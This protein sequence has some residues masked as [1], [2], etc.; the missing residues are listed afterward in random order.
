MPHVVAIVN[1]C[2]ADHN[3]D[4][5]LR[6]SVLQLLD[7]LIDDQTLGPVFGGSAACTTLKQML[8]PPLVWRAGKTASALRFAGITAMASFFTHRLID[9]ETLR[10][11]LDAGDLL[12]VVFQAL[13]EDYYPDVRNTACYVVEQ[14]ILIA[15]NLLGDAHRRSL[16][17][18]LCK[19]LD[20]SND[21]V[22]I[23]ACGPLEAFV[24]TMPVDYCPTNSGYFVSSLLIHM[25]DSDQRIQE[26]VYK[27]VEGVA[28]KKPD[29][30]ETEIEKV[31]CRFRCKQYC[32][33]ALLVC[34]RARED[35]L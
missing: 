23:S 28:R 17:P 31:K 14:L 20:D 16:Y 10:D 1:G 3:R 5:A 18:E 4:P 13:E 26:A 24:A 15:G 8:L 30:V 32:D 35:R 27:I 12:P 34:R 22:R 6:L 29:V 19:R 33:Q 11:L 9:G 2:L 7:D 25:D 21:Q